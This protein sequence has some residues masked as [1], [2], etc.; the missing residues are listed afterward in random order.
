MS[1]CELPHDACSPQSPPQGSRCL[2]ALQMT[3][4]LLHL[5]GR[6][7]CCSVC[8]SGTTAKA[9]FA[10]VLLADDAAFC[11]STTYGPVLAGS[12]PFRTGDMILYAACRYCITNAGVAAVG[13]PP[14]SALQELRLFALGINPGSVAQLA[15]VAR[16]LRVLHLQG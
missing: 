10:I 2:A 3:A 1:L 14:C 7:H 12:G 9:G 15:P 4:W 6:C 13:Y 8:V 16:Q 11:T 5:R